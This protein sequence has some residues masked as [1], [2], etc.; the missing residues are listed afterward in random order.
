MWSRP[1][2]QPLARRAFFPV[3]LG[4][5]RYHVDGETSRDEVPRGRDTSS[6]IALSPSL[7]LSFTELITE[8]GHRS[9]ARRDTEPGRCP[10][11]DLLE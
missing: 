7:F 1:I 11:I 4:R 2:G 6:S 9:L 10:M 8:D 3:R 5:E